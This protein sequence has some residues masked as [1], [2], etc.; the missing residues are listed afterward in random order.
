MNLAVNACDLYDNFD[1]RQDIELRRR[2]GDYTA[3]KQAVGKAAV[4]RA[5]SYEQLTLA[6]PLADDYADQNSKN[7]VRFFCTTNGLFAS[8]SRG[9]SKGILY[10]VNNGQGGQNNDDTNEA[11]YFDGGEARIVA[12]LQKQVTIS[13]VNTFSWHKSDRAPQMFSLWACAS[14]AAPEADLYAAD[15]SGWTLIARVETESLGEGGVHVSSV[16]FP[17][18]RQYRH[19]MWVADRE[20]QGT[21]FTEFDVIIAE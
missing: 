11:T 5:D 8:P 1:G 16:T 6:K 21:F 13:K 4:E 9:L 10:R 17:A 14:D 19:L 20:A 12:D 18:D 15:G 3:G 2:P 7:N